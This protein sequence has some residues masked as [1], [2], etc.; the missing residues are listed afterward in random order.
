MR[1][2]HRLALMLN[3]QAQ[4][5]QLIG[6]N[7]KGFTLVELIMAM[8]VTAII[9]SAVTTVIYQVFNMNARSSNHM[10]A[11]RQVQNAGYWV[12]HDAQMA[13]STNVTG[14]DFLV[15]KWTDWNNG[16]NQV[17]YTLENASGGVKNLRRT[18]SIDSG[19]GPVVQTNSLV[20]QYIN[21]TLTPPPVFA[22]NKLI[23]TVTAT[24]GTGSKAVSETRIYEVKPR[25]GL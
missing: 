4:R 14:A 18:Y 15:L 16:Q 9:A 13:Q 8:A 5:C 11:V 10:V 2:F 20:G 3:R 22:S 1:L 25:P 7:Q 12:S 17:T 24:V 19:S 21:P 23:F 6:S